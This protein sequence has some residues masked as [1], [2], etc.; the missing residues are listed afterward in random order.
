[1]RPDQMDAEQTMNCRVDFDRTTLKMLVMEF[2]N[3]GR[4][5]SSQGPC[6]ART[7]RTH[8]VGNGTG[9]YGSKEGSILEITN[10][11]LGSRDNKPSDII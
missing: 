4:L 9:K 6:L 3:A 8:E 7:L 10:M 11:Y 5:T 2:G 1:M